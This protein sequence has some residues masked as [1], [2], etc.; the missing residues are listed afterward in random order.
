MDWEHP[1][2]LNAPPMARPR[3][4]LGIP[5]SKEESLISTWEVPHEYKTMVCRGIATEPVRGQIRPKGR[6]KGKACVIVTYLFFSCL[7]P[8]TLDELN[9]PPLQG[10]RQM[11]QG[12]A[13]YG[14]RIY[15]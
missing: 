4:I 6:H 13:V 5:F 3:M 11:W 14:V 15:Q 7:F 9:L 1:A 12:R 10:N 8:V 2:V